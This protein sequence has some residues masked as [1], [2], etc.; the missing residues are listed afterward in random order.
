M[1]KF[2]SV[3]LALLMMSA[4]LT[5]CSK[6]P[7]DSSKT[8][9]AAVTEETTAETGGENEA[10]AGGWTVNSEF[11]EAEIPEDAKAAFDKAM[12][13]Y[14][15]MGFKPV[16]YLGSQV[17]AGA[18]YAFL[19]EGTTMTAE[20]VTS[21]KIVTVYAG[22]DDTAEVKDVVDVNVAPSDDAEVEFIPSDFTGA[23][24]YTEA[25]GAALPENAAEAFDKAVEGLAGVSYEPIALLGTQVV[26]GQNL[27]VL[28]KAASVTAEPATALAVVY[29]Y[30][31]LEG[32]A[33]ITGVNG[34]KF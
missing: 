13:G 26:A 32:G 10:E 28:C 7:A 12:E 8:T 4:A 23:Y 34:I 15:G 2:I 20:P 27:A 24:D 17:V 6:T 11:G 1:K 25:A 9:E 14:T 30:A 16:A 3:S 18:N 21:L 33:T 22:V 5:A 19:C 29:V 31:D